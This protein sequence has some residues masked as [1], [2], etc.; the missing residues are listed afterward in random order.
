LAKTDSLDA[1]VL[2]HFAEAVHP[3]P[4][5]LSDEATRQVAALLERR[6]QV[7]GMLTAEKTRHHQAVGHVRTLI[8]AH[9]TW[10]PAALDE[11]KG[12]PG[13]GVAR[14]PALA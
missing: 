2:A 1:H 11:L 3:E 14:Q 8:A 4:R 6:A 5:P 10:L 7:V 12:G 9:I 13:P